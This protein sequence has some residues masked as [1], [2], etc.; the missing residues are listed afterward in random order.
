MNTGIYTAQRICAQ[1]ALGFFSR[2]QNILAINQSYDEHKE[3]H[4]QIDEKCIL[5]HMYYVSSCVDVGFMY[6]TRTHFL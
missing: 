4:H 3:V 6:N 2:I 1:R 5:L